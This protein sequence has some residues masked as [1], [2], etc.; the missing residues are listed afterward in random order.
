LR[1]K[2]RSKSPEH[3][4]PEARVLPGGIN[5]MNYCAACNKGP[6]ATSGEVGMRFISFLSAFDRTQ[7]LV[8]GGKVGK[9]NLKS[10]LDPEAWVLPGGINAMNYRAACNKGLASTSAC[11]L[12]HS[13]VPLT[14]HKASFAEKKLVKVT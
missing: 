13:S 1:R 11:D 3:F 9:S 5:A 12:F 14:A 2:S 10:H 7:G 6:A 4:S 8:C